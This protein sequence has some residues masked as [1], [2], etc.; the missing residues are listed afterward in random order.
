MPVG[1]ASLAANASDDLL[2]DGVGYRLVR[3]ELHRV[4]R[5]PLGAGPQVAN[6]PEH[7]GQRDFGVDDLRA[8]ALLDALDLTAPRVE[9]ADDVAH[10][11][12][13]RYALD[14]HDRLE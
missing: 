7:L 13:G 9:V 1:G 11:F 10:V 12:V 4:G 2:G 6:I 3:V 5:A 14:R 8:A